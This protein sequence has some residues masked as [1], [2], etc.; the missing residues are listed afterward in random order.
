MS[1]ARGPASTSIGHASA[2]IDAARPAS[3]PTSSSSRGARLGRARR[4]TSRAS[5]RERVE[6]AAPVGERARR[7]DRRARGGRG[8]RS[9]RDALARAIDNLADATR[10]KRRQR[11][12]V[13]VQVGR[14]TASPGCVVADR[15]AGVHPE[16][17]AR[18]LRAVLHD[19]ARGHR[20]RARHLPRHRPAHGGSVTYGRDGEVTRFELALPGHRSREARRS[21]GARMTRRARSSRTSAASAKGS[22]DALEDARLPTRTPGRASPRRARR[23]RRRGVDCVLLDIRL[24]DGDGLDSCASCAPGRAARRA[25]DRGH[26]LRRQRADDPRH[27]RRRVR[28]PHQAVR[29]AAPR[30]DRR[31]GA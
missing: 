9:T 31:A 26:R 17:R 20:P 10:S 18:A 29:P 8:V 25:G 6:V 27:A 24:R 14:K 23:W 21:G 22:G 19:Q 3:S 15:G 11:R 30:R 7:A 5:G 12:T 4:S 16:P 28:L 2:E 13:E 1:A